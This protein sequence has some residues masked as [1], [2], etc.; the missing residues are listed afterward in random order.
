MSEA[1]MSFV[2]LVCDYNL[3]FLSNKVEPRVDSRLTYGAY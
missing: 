2:E 3:K 1:Q